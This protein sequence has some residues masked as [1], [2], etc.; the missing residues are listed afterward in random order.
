MR[1]QF[2]PQ[3]LESFALMTQELYRLLSTTI[4][5]TRT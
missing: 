5:H 1:E 2:E 3:I 4:Q